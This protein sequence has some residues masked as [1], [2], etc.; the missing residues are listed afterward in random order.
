MRALELRQWLASRLRKIA[1]RLDGC[2]SPLNYRLDGADWALLD[3]ATIRELE[4]RAIRRLLE[5]LFAELRMARCE[6]MLD[7]YYEGRK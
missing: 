3:R 1:Q 5:D 6:R 2:S 7:E 4:L